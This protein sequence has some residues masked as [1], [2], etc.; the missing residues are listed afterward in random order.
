MLAFTLSMD[1]A[2]S[3]DGS[4]KFMTIYTQ[5]SGKMMAVSYSILKNHHDAEEAVQSALLSIHKNIDWV[6]DGDTEHT[7]NYCLKAAKNHAINIANRRKYNCELEKISIEDIKAKSDMHFNDDDEPILDAICNMKPI[8]RDVLI[9]KYVYELSVKQIAQ[10]FGLPTQTV[11]SRLARG[12]K[13][14]R[15]KFKEV[16]KDV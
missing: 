15:E 13:I 16:R 12:I 1:F 3:R 6:P 14:I 8:Y 10:S 5:Y 9:A 2:K 4:D 7:K 11:K